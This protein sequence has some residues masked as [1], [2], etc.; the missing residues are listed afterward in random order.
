M[1][2]AAPVNRRSDARA[3][4]LEP[5]SPAMAEK[6]DL[7]SKYLDAEIR[8]RVLR[9]RIDRPERRN[10]NT[11]EMYRGY[12]RAAILA[13]GDP[14]LDVLLLTGTG[15]WFNVGGDMSG[16]SED[17]AG[18]AT[19]LDPTDHFPFRHLERCRKVVF[20][21]VNGACHAGG[22]NLLMYSDLS[23]ASDRATFRAPELLRGAPDPWI[24]ARLPEYVGLGAAKYLLFT[25]AR[26]DAQEA[27][28]MG[29]IGK[30]VP[31]ERF[32]E[33]VETVLDQIRLTGPKTR[34]TIKAEINR[35]LPAPNPEV[36]RR[37][38]LSAE[39]VEGMKAFIEKRKPEWPRD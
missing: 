4:A 31:H 25:A 35:T 11:Q 26:F 6:I 16:E 10:A 2:A 15:D 12:K 8:D 5:E 3:T 28:Q 39:M 27:F 22:L 34:S 38:I 32:D 21:A 1:L 7:G 33:E 23:I 20:A 36:F 9:V 19:E 14:Q 13:D 37:S 18:L 24:A 30:V 29:L 17:P